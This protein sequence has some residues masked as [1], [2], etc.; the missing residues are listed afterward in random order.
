M[1]VE[2]VLL[3]ATLFLL[4]YWYIAK[5]FGKWERLGIPCISGRFPYGS[6][7]ALI[8]QKKHFFEIGLEEYEQFKD[9]DYFGTY[10]LGKPVL[11]IN[12]IDMIKDILVKNFNN[13][14][15]R[16]DTNLSKVF[17]GGK[18]D[19]LWKNQ[20]T[21]LSGDDWKDVR[22]T[23]TP[24]F[25][26]GKMRSMYKFMREIG[27][28]LANELGEK[29]DAKAE[30]KLK[31]VFG[32]FSLDTLAT[33][34]F[35][36]DPGS[37]ENN[38]SKFVQAASN[39]FRQSFKDN[40]FVFTRLIPG[41]QDIQ[42]MMNISIIKP[43]ETKFFY[44]VIKQSIEDRRKT[45]KRENDLIDLMIDCIKDE[46]K[47]D[48]NENCVDQ[49]EQYEKD[50]QF[51]HSAKNKQFDEDMIIATSLVL[52]SAGYDTT[53][54]TLSFLG[55]ELGKNPDIQ[56]KLQEEIDQAFE[57]NDG[58]LPDYN[59]IQGLPYLDSCIHETLRL[60]TPVGNLFRTCNEETKLL[61][62]DYVIG[63]NDLISISAIGIHKDERY[64]PNPFEF[65]PD[66]F[67][68][69]A[70]QSRSPYTFLSFGQGPR[71][72]IGMRFALLEAKVAMALVMKEFNFLPS[73]KNPEKLV[74]DVEA[75]LGDIKGGIWSN[76]E[77]R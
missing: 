31:D 61:G 29:A 14:V 40:I 54:M 20:L 70:R 27:F 28:R 48:E 76:V 35:G 45:G 65:N 34:A 37:F 7:S 10:L 13:F 64:Y 16:N 71:A 47:Q 11:N 9:K 18:W 26:S 41:L 43:K 2:I 56:E 17:D 73:D 75:Q 69:E 42:K 21:N 8:T 58:K 36:I 32:K 53:G 39:I 60:H 74:L 55:Y 66:N 68:K 46:A 67:S 38:D 22:S 23:F 3:L 72:C 33:C 50:M 4:L 62:T 1:L 5:N 25:T 57:E 52:L 24:I 15:D 30:F 19:Q 49:E 77:R 59:V 6:H 44:D 63:K 12:N 51:K